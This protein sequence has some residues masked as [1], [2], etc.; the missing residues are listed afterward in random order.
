VACDAG[1]RLAA[2]DVHTRRPADV[3]IAELAGELTAALLNSPE[4]LVRPARGWRGAFVRL[5]A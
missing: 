2:Y 5:G 1:S 3:I 4:V